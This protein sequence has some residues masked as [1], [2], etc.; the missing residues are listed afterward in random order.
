[1]ISYAH[2]VLAVIRKDGIARCI[3]THWHN[4]TEHYFTDNC[5]QLTVVSAK[6]TT[7]RTY[8]R[9]YPNRGVW[10]RLCYFEGV[11]EWR[12]LCS[13]TFTDFSWQSL[14]TIIVAHKRG[15]LSWHSC[16]GWTPRWTQD[17]LSQRL[18][19]WQSHSLPDAGLVHIVTTQDRYS[20]ILHIHAALSDKTLGAE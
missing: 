17:V 3:L 7:D 11:R 1:M 9:H 12:W 18:V 2:K 16:C 15:R 19:D 10:I 14:L 8:L 4:I 5:G 6:E 20:F 13:V